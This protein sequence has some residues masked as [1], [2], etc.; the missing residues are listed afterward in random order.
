[1]IEIEKRFYFYLIDFYPGM[2]VGE[3]ELEPATMHHLRPCSTTRNKT[4]LVPQTAAFTEAAATIPLTC[5]AE[6]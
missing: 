2:P 5:P 1:M 3:L 6:S 4:P